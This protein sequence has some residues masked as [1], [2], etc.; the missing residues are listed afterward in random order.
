MPKNDPILREIAKLDYIL[1]DAH[2]AISYWGY[3]QGNPY[4][5]LMEK[6]ETIVIEDES[7]L[8]HKLTMDDLIKA[9]YKMKTEYTDDFKLF[10]EEQYDVVTC[11]I[12][13]QLAL[14][15]QIVYG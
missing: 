4:N 13:I 14:F 1:C 7:N 5:E 9:L 15:D 8:P 11:D 10:Q 2:P 6:G 12:L 3:F